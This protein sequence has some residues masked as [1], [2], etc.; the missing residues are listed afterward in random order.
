M[1]RREHTTRQT[2]NTFSDADIPGYLSCN[3]ASKLSFKDTQEQVVQPCCL[4]VTGVNSNIAKADFCRVLADYHGSARSG[5]FG[6]EL[7]LDIA[8]LEMHFSVPTAADFWEGVLVVVEV[9]FDCSPQANH[10]EGN[11]TM[12]VWRHTCYCCTDVKGLQDNAGQVKADSSNDR[13]IPA[14]SCIWQVKLVE[15]ILNNLQCHLG[16]V[17]KQCSGCYACDSWLVGWQ[18]GVEKGVFSLLK[19]CLLTL[20]ACCC[21]QAEE[22]QQQQAS[23]LKTTQC[24]ALARW[25]VPEACTECLKHNFELLQP[26]LL[27]LTSSRL[28]PLESISLGKPVSCH[29]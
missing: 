6:Y 26:G 2:A 21:G 24:H 8:I 4:G 14:A 27:E 25:Q 15:L 16:G 9:A 18:C 12:L 20:H 23:S 29:G 28:A 10:N 1:L 19:L 3:H 22:R 11:S 5:C 7:E 13:D 17:R